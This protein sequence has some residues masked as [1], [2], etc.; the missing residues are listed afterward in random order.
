MVVSID[1]GE[2][3]IIHPT[4]KA[5]IGH[6][7]AL[8]ARALTYGEPISCSGPALAS[9]ERQGGAL[10]LR[11]NPAQDGLRTR[12]SRPVGG[13]EVCGPDGVYYP[14]V[15]EIDGET[16]VVRCER[17]S[18]PVGVRYGWKQDPA[19]ANLTNA[20]GLPAAPFVAVGGKEFR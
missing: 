5:P 13:C 8:L 6:R 9:L 1:L 17:V 15:A 19:E 20:T 4:N 18:E 14:A 3:A 11:F 16:L 2:P 12:D 10:R 7:L